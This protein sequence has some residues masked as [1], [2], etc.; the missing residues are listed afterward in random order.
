MPMIY[1]NAKWLTTQL[2]LMQLTDYEIWYADYQEEPIYP[3]QFRIW[4]YTEEGSVPGI[5]GYVDLN[6]CFEGY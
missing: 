2:D 1:A 4:Q 6:V 3:Y 5:D